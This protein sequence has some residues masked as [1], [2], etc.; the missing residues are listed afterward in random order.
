MVLPSK[1]TEK[2][3]ASQQVAAQAE[4][5]PGNEN[6]QHVRTLTIFYMHVYQVCYS[7]FLLLFAGAIQFLKGI[8]DHT[9]KQHLP[10]K[11]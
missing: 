7:Y 1:K 3:A 5:I 8:R 10:T 11:L 2:I 6:E 4:E 9:S